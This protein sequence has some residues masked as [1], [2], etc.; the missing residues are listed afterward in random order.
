[1]VFMNCKNLG[2]LL[3]GLITNWSRTIYGPLSSNGN[4]FDRCKSQPHYENMIL[5]KL[6]SDTFIQVP[7]TR[8]GLE[9]LQSLISEQGYVNGYT[10]LK[11]GYPPTIGNLSNYGLHT[12]KSR[13]DQRCFINITHTLHICLNFR[14]A[15]W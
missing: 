7:P 10:S 3:Q 8:E 14:E 13:Q 9:C 4:H 2:I 15:V 5:G 12:I 11:V 1:M 6:S